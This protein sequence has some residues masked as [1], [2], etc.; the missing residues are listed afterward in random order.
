MTTKVLLRIS[1]ALLSLITY[2]IAGNYR[3]CSANYCENQGTVFENLSQKTPF[4]NVIVKY[5]MSSKLKF[6]GLGTK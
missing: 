3:E 4:K 6:V 1:I 2:V 5:E